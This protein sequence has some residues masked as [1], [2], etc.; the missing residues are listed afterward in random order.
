MDIEKSPIST[1]KK[2]VLLLFEYPKSD[3]G[4]YKQMQY[5]RRKYIEIVFPIQ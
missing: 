5:N 2:V 4:I 3:L 1:F